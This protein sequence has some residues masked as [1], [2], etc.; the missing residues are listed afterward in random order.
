M[1]DSKHSDY[2]RGVLLSVAAFVIGEYFLYLRLPFGYDYYMYRR[3]HLFVV[4]PA[5]LLFVGSVLLSSFLASAASGANLDQCKNG[6]FGATPVDPCQWVNGNLN[7]NQAHYIEGQSIAYRAVMT[8]L[9]IGTHTLTIGYDITR[10][11]KHA[12]DYLTSYRRITEAVDPCASIAD[13]GGAPALYN[14]AAFLS[15][16]NSIQNSFGLEPHDSIAAL[17]ALE[18]Q[19]SIWNGEI[20]N[21]EYVSQ[22][23]LSA[24]QSEAIVKI[25]FTASSPT[26]VIAWGGHIASALDWG[27]GAAAGNISGSPYH[28]RLHDLDGTGGNQDRSLTNAQVTLSPAITISKS[29]S[30]ATLPLGGGQVTYTYRVGNGGNSSLAQISVTDNKCSPLSYVSGDLNNDQRLDVSEIWTYTCTTGIAQTTTNTALASGSSGGVPVTA[31]TQATVQV[32]L[33][34]PPPPLI[35]VVKTASPASL[36]SGGGSVTYSYTL[37]NPG[38]V[39]LSSVIV[40]DNKCSPITLTGGDT[41]NDSKLD[42]SETWHYTC[43]KTITTT[44]TNIAT[45]TGVANGLTALDTAQATVTVAAPA[46]PVI[47]VAKSA[48]PSSLPSGGGAVTYSY[49]ITNPGVVALSGVT[50]TDNTCASPARIGGDTNNN[51]ILEPTETWRYSCTKTVTTTTTNIASASGTNAGQTASS[52]ARATVTV[53]A[54]APQVVALAAPVLAVSKSAS[55]SSLPSG[56]GQV[57]Y[58][59]T[60]TNPGTTAVSSVSVSDNKCSPV[61]RISGDTNNNNILEPT[62]TWTYHCSMSITQ[63]TTNTALAS[64][65]ANGQNTQATAQATVS[66]AVSGAPAI[67]VSKSASPSSLPSGGGAV[68]YTFSITNPGTAALSSVT[69]TDDKCSPLTRTGGDTNNNN[70]LE[71]NE[72]WIYTCSASVLQTTTDTATARGTSGNQTAQSSAQAT[73]TV[74]QAPVAAPQQAA[75]PLVHVVKSASP[76][77]LPQG[78]GSVTYFYVVTNPGSSGLSNV[79]V[80]DNLCPSVS[81]IGGDTNGDNILDPSETWRFSCT[82]NITQTTTNRAT[83]RGSANSQIASDEALATVQVAPINPNISPM[84][85][86]IVVPNPGTLPSGGGT[87]NYT[88][89]VTTPGSLPLDNVALSDTACFGISFV[90][91]DTNGNGKLDPNEIWTYSCQTRLLTTTQNIVTARTRTAGITVSDTARAIVVVGAKILLVPP[92]PP[93]EQSKIEAIVL[94]KPPKTGRLLAL[95]SSGLFGPLVYTRTSTLPWQLVIPSLNIASTIESV[96][97]NAAGFMAVPTTLTTVAWFNQGVA[98]GEIGNAVI[99][100]HIGNPVSDKGV[101]WNLE[102]IQVGDEISVVRDARTYTFV[103]TDAQVYQKDSL[104]LDRIFGSSATANLNLITCAGEWDPVARDYSHRLVVF[105]KAL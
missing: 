77:N 94:P 35:N 29:A 54:P 46:T 1:L 91:G 49:S 3:I 93:P 67:A 99:D 45:S 58:T 105:A 65:T 4:L 11:S 2:G 75:V 37:T 51:N 28:M 84:I 48:S 19:M 43:S 87:V 7:A 82:M 60:L 63:T 8:G 56:G 27:A 31:S 26:V 88:Y 74:A 71:T 38:A 72:T 50:L 6:G 23:D 25:T 14:L 83:V 42:P 40:T 55:P 69:V 32:T 95:D 41:N 80:V 47:A 81:Q 52:T 89:R 62:E 53:A 5:A 39:A 18:K 85:N 57:T 61:T 22:G 70:I 78:G 100:G 20:T 44:T 16:T 66:V 96:G 73:V 21:V 76:S 13:C 86:V 30:P 104:P 92:P 59:Y 68:V 102:R 9:S 24:S 15:T 79:S 36:P 98:P 103:V 10:S 90:G 34:P 64:G 97:L 33:P 12:L 101:F 17:P